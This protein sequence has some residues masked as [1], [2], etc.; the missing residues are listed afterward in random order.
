MD[1]NGL[2][3]MLLTLKR[4]PLKL[5]VTDKEVVDSAHDLISLKYHGKQTNHIFEEKM[6]LADQPPAARLLKL[7]KNY[8][9]TGDPQALNNI[10]DSDNNNMKIKN[11]QEKTQVFGYIV[12]KIKKRKGNE[13]K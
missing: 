8:A 2:V 6:K 12:E 10:I 13:K 1:G 5:R 7:L 4:G 3:K 9:D 11:N